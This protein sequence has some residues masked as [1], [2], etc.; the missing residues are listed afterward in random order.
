MTLFDSY[1][2]DGVS[3]V[4]GVQHRGP[5]SGCE[6]VTDFDSY[7]VEGVSAVIGVQHREVPNQGASW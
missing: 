7:S 5:K 2:Y 3:A 4:I 1:T 6:L